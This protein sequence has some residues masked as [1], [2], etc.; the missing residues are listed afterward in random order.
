MFL[1]GIYYIYV[2]V[3]VPE[4]AEAVG[5]VRIRRSTSWLVL[6]RPFGSMNG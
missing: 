1:Y 4:E 6:H 3:Y 5:S 2:L